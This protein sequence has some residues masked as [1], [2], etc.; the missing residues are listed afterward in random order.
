[1]NRS[2]MHFLKHIH[3]YL[4]LLLGLAFVCC[5]AG[6]SALSYSNTGSTHGAA[7]FASANTAS[8]VSASYKTASTLHRSPAHTRSH[9]HFSLRGKTF[10]KLLMKG[11]SSDV[12]YLFHQ[13]SIEQV[14]GIFPLRYLLIAPPGY[15]LFLF[16][17]AL[18]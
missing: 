10:V 12:L 15:Y 18:F 7:Y 8:A 16:R 6:V 2:E 11:G 3:K 4:G 5:V 14:T 9:C 17:Y 1:M 13:H